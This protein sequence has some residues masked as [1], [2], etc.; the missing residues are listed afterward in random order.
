MWSTMGKKFW[1]PIYERNFGS[2]LSVCP[3]SLRPTEKIFEQR[4]GDGKGKESLNAPRR[5]GGGGGGGKNAI[6]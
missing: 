5:G 2:D 3:P 4:E 1:L 6:F